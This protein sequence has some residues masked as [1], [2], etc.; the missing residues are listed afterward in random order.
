MF[1]WY[2][3][4]NLNKSREFRQKTSPSLINLKS[5]ADS[6]RSS[7]YCLSPTPNTPPSASS[8]SP[9][10]YY[11]SPDYNSNNSFDKDKGEDCKCRCWFSE[12]DWGNQSMRSL[13]FSP[14]RNLHLTGALA[15]LHWH[16]HLQLQHPGVSHN[17]QI[18]S[19]GSPMS[20]TCLRTTPRCWPRCWRPSPAS[21]GP[22]LA[23]AS[24]APPVRGPSPPWWRAP[25]PPRRRGGSHRA[26][27]SEVRIILIGTIIVMLCFTK[28]QC[29]KKEE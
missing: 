28:F 23:S 29:Q 5:P 22:C 9:K 18:I 8:S 15:R 25:A 6:R 4:T 14:N 12:R 7:K 26:R 16:V 13:S 17:D 24:G 27:S 3:V 21:P 10:S 2:W 11:S 20:R 1:E 19:L